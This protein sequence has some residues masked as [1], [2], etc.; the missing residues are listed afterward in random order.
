MMKVR[1][2][3]ETM[4]RILETVKPLA[5]EENYM[6]IDFGTA[7]EEGVGEA[8][9]IMYSKVSIT[10]GSEQIE[11]GFTT[12]VPEEVDRPLG[13]C[14]IQNPLE[15]AVFKS[16]DFVAVV[17]ALSVYGQAFDLSTDASRALISVEGKAEMP[18]YK[19]D[20]GAMKALIPHRENCEDLSVCDKDIFTMRLYGK[21]FLSA[22]KTSTTL[23]KKMDNAPSAFKVYTVSVK[24]KPLETV[25]VD[26]GN[27]GK[28]KVPRYNAKVQILSTDTHAFA[29]GVTP[30]Y[31]HKG[32]GVDMIAQMEKDENLRS[33]L[34]KDLGDGK[35]ERI[36]NPVITVKKVEM[37]DGEM[38]N[39]PTVEAY[40]DFKKAYDLARGLNLPETEFR[41]GIPV[42]VMDRLVRMMSVVPESYL[43]IT[44][45][46]KYILVVISGLGCI[47]VATHKTLPS[48]DCFKT[49]ADIFEKTLLQKNSILFDAKDLSNSLKIAQLYEKDQLI[50]QMP[51]EMTFEKKGITIKRG[52]AVSVVNAISAETTADALTWGFNGTYIPLITAGLSA[53][54]L[55]CRYSA[56]SAVFVFAK[57]NEELTL[58]TPVMLVTGVQQLSDVKKQIVEEHERKIAAA[59][60]KKREKDEK[61]KSKEN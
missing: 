10:N 19:A 21:D 9:A 50:K 38:K 45:G 44:V 15:K 32:A 29:N 20:A 23:S 28:V 31:V 6:S 33:L 26:D 43:D 55:Q 59:E 49:Y 2:E 35:V 57:A 3:I 12:T 16:S 36:K 58:E 4:N 17:D 39:E 34:V 8:P 42:D 41:F 61:K 48:A 37:G 56:E 1:I 46:E 27:G 22:A 14:D 11:A 24:D 30:A 51:L 52:E 7:G 53:G 54:T 40:A 5:T 25:E 60:A 18:V 13:E 47:Y